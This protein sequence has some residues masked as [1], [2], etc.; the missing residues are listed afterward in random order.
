ME[1][2]GKN[3]KVSRSRIHKYTFPVE[4]KLLAKFSISELAA[5]SVT[6][7]DL[8]TKINDTWFLYASSGYFWRSNEISRLK[9]YGIHFFHYS[10]TE[11]KRVET[12]RALGT[13]ELGAKLDPGLSVEER[14]RFLMQKSAG[15]TELLFTCSLGPSFIIHAKQIVNDLL[16]MLLEDEP[17]LVHMKDLS[18]GSSYFNEHGFKVAAFALTLAIK[19]TLR[20]PAHLLQIGLGALLHDV[21]QVQFGK[22]ML[23]RPAKLDLDETKRMIKHPIYGALELEQFHVDFITAQ[24][25][26]Q[27]HERLDGSGYPQGM[28]RYEIL[29][30]VVVVMIAD[31]Y[32]GLV[33][34]R[35]YQDKVNHSQAIDALRSKYQKKIDQDFVRAAS[36]VF[37]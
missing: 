19:L 12:Y 20:D 4:E 30:E 32:D 23:F 35:P 18:V 1:Q 28:Q 5:N 36:E 8:F 29:P 24:I 17:V 2:T 27:H 9:K 10:T 11:Q 15:L 3:E 34:S 25:V 37:P 33:S 6:D 31:I 21:G 13:L 26:Q 7:F 14:L 16:Q 22:E